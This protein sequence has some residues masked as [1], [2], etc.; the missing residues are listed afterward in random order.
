MTQDLDRRIEQPRQALSENEL[1]A[2]A[3]FAIGLGSEGG[4]GGRDVSYELRFAGNIDRATGRMHPVGNSGYSIGTLQTDLGQH[5]SAQANDDVPNE[6]VDRYQTWA[7][8]HANEHPG[9]VLSEQQREQT[10]SDLRRQGNEIRENNGV[11]LDATIKLR[12]NT[13]LASDD[14][15]TYVHDRDVAQIDKLLREADGRRDLGSGLTRLQETTLY[16]DSSLDDQ[17]HLATMIAKVENQSGNAYYPRIITGINNGTLDSVD[18]VKGAVDGL[19][20]NAANGRPDYIEEGVN[21]ALR[22]TE[23]LNGLRN[24][25]PRSPLNLTWQNVVAD[26][27]VNPV[28][29]RQNA[30]AG[31]GRVW[32][33]EWLPEQQNP[34]A[35]PPL[36][37]AQANPNL[38]AQYDTVKTLFLNPDQALP[39]INA[40]DEG[41]TY[42][43]GRPQ[44]EGRNGPTAGFYAAG[45]DFVV[46]NREGNGHAFIDG[47]WQ[48]IERQN[49][50][51]VRNEDGTTD[52]NITRNGEVTRLLHIDPRAPA[53]HADEPAQAPAHPAA[54]R[55]GVPGA[56][57]EAEGRDG[58]ERPGQPDHPARDGQA[59]AF[60]PGSSNQALYDRLY[61]SARG[62]GRW[63]EEQSHNI[64]ASGLAATKDNP[65]VRRAD[66]IGIYNGQLFVSYFPHGKGVEPMFNAR[67]DPEQAAQV[68]ARE[69]LQR[70]DQIDQQRTQ[71][72]TQQ[73]EL[74]SNGLNGPS[75]GARVA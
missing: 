8:A 36:R 10:V 31:P 3:F 39:F 55:M 5:R 60:P 73:Q 74:Q 14:G 25:D 20:R 19:M 33:P 28:D 26:P 67:I 13:Y 32:E 46:W 1:R 58:P 4:L 44:S 35:V 72:L 15:V 50:S 17:A 12:I 54:L 40:L 56:R 11:D 37:A 64:A 2:T 43:Y 52:L 48:D 24:A 63:D 21:H 71:T 9:W 30:P 42:H 34:A 70:V 7:R 57:A 51:R 49:L 75:I 68:P 47:Q 22:G 23:V 27:L 53:V 45:N 29:L 6:L 65:T 18:A 38:G 66:D 69:S 61:Q 41:R 16:Q 62:Q 59:H